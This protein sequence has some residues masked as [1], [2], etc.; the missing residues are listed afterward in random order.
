MLVN[1]GTRLSRYNVRLLANVSITSFGFVRL[2]VPYVLRHLW[3]D[4]I[5]TRQ[6]HLGWDSAGAKGISYHG[7]K[8]VVMVFDK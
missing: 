7:N 5:K 4:R 3:T 2:S 6:G 8:K 1:I